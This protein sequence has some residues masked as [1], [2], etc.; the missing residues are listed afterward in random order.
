MKILQHQFRHLLS[1]I[2]LY[3][4][5]YYVVSHY[6]LHVFGG[7]LWGINTDVWLIIAVLS[8]ILYQI[9]VLICWRLE[10]YGQ[11]I[12]KTFGKENGFKLYKIGFAILILS[13]MVTLVLLA[14]S[15]GDSLHMNPYFHI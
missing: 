7:S 13:R 12:S 1:L 11:L 2:L 8:P 3:L 4:M 10:L 9:Y 6:Q 14:I 15:N 5:F